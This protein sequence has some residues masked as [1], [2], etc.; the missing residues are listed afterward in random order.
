MKFE[1][2]R[3]SFRNGECP[4]IG[5]A[6]ETYDHVD[7]ATYPMTED[8]FNKNP[9][10]SHIAPWRSFGD[11]HEEYARANGKKGIRRELH[12]PRKRWV[13]EI[14]S[15]DVLANF[16]EKV[17]GELVLSFVQDMPGIEIYDDYRE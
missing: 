14:E 9:S 3:T 16:A 5:C 8:Q 17:G 4:F 12:A 7:Y 15:L 13:L 2:K 10:Y 6:E 11:N 1:I